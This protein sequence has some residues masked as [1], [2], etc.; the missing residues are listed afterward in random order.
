MY[1]L[2]D[3]NYKNYFVKLLMRYDF[4]KVFLC[5]KKTSISSIMIQLSFLL[6]ALQPL[7]WHQVWWPQITVVWRVAYQSWRTQPQLQLASSVLNCVQED[8]IL[9]SHGPQAHLQVIISTLISR[10][11]KLILGVVLTLVK[12][13]FRKDGTLNISLSLWI[14]L[15]FPHIIPKTK[16]ILA[17]FYDTWYFLKKVNVES[18]AH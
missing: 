14:G 13:L 4:R 1:V 12:D 9:R 6:Q 18:M 17:N 15:K 16:K 11:C 2:V 8:A 3:W 10:I 7:G 5:D